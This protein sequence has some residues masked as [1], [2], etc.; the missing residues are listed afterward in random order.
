MRYS[1]LAGAGLLLAVAA[2]TWNTV[3][4][5]AGK[6]VLKVLVPQADAE[7]KIDGKKINGEGTEREIPAPELKKGK[8][9]LLVE[10]MWEPNNYTKIWRKKEVTP[11]AGKVVVDLREANP[12]IKDHIEVR[13]VPTPDDIVEA[14]CKLGKVTKSDVVYDL[15]CGDGRMVIIA[16]KKFGAKRGVG[17]DIDP[18]RIKESKQNANI[19]GVEDKV[20]F[21]VGDVLKVQDLSDADVVLLYMGDDINNRLKPI[22][23]KT[24]KSGA[25]VV[26]HRFTMGEWTPTKT[27]RVTGKDGREYS[28]HL[29]VIAKK[30]K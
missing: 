16:V 30:E 27:Q 13:Y 28:L 7:V 21:R 10:V 29:W 2:L 26:S 17:V 3:V 6:S 15:G 19:Q 8:K 12:A 24:L 22:L 20:Q 25:R 18:E 23:K 4:Q 9:A 5:A 1:R 11:K 14:M